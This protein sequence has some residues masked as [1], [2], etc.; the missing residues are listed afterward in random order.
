MSG[1]R[2]AE[3]RPGGWGAWGVLRLDFLRGQVEAIDEYIA[4][5]K[6]QPPFTLSYI[7]RACGQLSRSP[8]S[9]GQLLGL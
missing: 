2:E 3:G 6:V 7:P 5:G 8:D 9:L 4:V 1:G